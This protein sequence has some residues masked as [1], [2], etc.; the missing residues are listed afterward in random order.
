MA[1]LQPCLIFLAE[2]TRLNSLYW[3]SRYA[4]RRVA[5]MLRA[6]AATTTDKKDPR[7]SEIWGSALRGEQ[8]HIARPLSAFIGQLDQ[9]EA[10]LRSVAVLQM[11]SAFETALVNYYALCVLYLPYRLDA[12]TPFAG[13][14]DVLQRPAAFVQLRELAITRAGGALV[15]PYSQRI[16]HLVNKFKLRRPDVDPQVLT[17]IDAH[18]ELR[19]LIAH[20]QGLARADA[21]DLS[22]PEVLATR[23]AVDEATWK[24]VI[25]D[26]STVV[27][28]LDANIQAKVVKDQ[29]VALA[30]FHIIEQ[31]GEATVAELRHR[32]LSER[33]LDALDAQT[34]IDSARAIGLVVVTVSPRVVKIRR[35]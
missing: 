15:G 27:E 28:A 11:C 12:D 18:Q 22:V 5:D 10:D 7:V 6:I 16:S 25:D 32:I 4:Y 35:S 14:P 8:R 21:P 24:A 23:M 31:E 2:T 33:N 34:I 3:T 29:G 13:V 26:F 19:H 1:K 17:N 20:D 9:N 30:I